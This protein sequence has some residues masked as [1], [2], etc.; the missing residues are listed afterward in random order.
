MIIK[1]RRAQSST[2]KL[3]LQTYDINDPDVAVFKRAMERVMSEETFNDNLL[4][5]K[6]IIN[7]EGGSKKGKDEKETVIPNENNEKIEK[8]DGSSNN[9]ENQNQK[10]FNNINKN[11]KN[12]FKKLVTNLSITSIILKIK[13]FD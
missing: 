13:R 10:I 2:G 5:D 4:L 8:S 11:N 6:S 1:R 9:E 7:C 12:N 3:V